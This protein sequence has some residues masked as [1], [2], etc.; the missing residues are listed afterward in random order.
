MVLAG[1]VAGAAYSPAL[2]NGFTLDDQAIVEEN[3]AAHDVGAA[4]RAA[5]SSYWP[6]PH[7]AGQWRPL[8][9]LSFATD[10][11]LSGG[12]AAWLHAGNVL[13][14]ATATALLV[15][16][17]IPYAGLAGATVGALVFAVHPVHVEAVAN[18]VGRAELMAAVLLL[19]AVLFA[20]AG[21]A[22]VAAG[23][24]A[25]GCEVGVLACLALALLSKEHAAVGILLLVLDRWALTTHP[26]LRL[27]ARLVAAALALTAIWFVAR[28]Q[29][30]VGRSF[31]AVAPTFFDQDAT[32]RLATMLPVVFHVVRLL[33]WPFQLSPDYHP[34]VVDRLDAVT[35][36]GLAGAAFLLLLLALGL[37]VRRRHPAVSAALGFVAIAWL[38]TA[39]LLFPTGIVLSERTLY[40]ASVGIALLAGLGAVALERRYGRRVATAL[41]VA[42][43]TAFGARTLTRIPIWESTRTLVLEGVL[44]RPESYKVRQAAARVLMRT[45]DVPAALRE[46]GVAAELYDWDPFLLAE[47]GSAALAGGQPLVALRFLEL[48]LARD[49]TYT[50]TRQLLE[51]ARREACDERPRLQNARCR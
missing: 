49:S 16:V 12:R 9:I 10:W 39:N 7:D 15:P 1:L 2:R 42:T 5:G 13:W 33:V 48:A 28:A 18:L 21:A 32:G 24:S 19:L 22:R 50:L 17:L 45:G 11:Q 27:R 23:A 8:V 31:A 34:R 40:L 38:P 3:P 30:D 46:Y 44:T 20:R 26:A 47:A 25:A 43:V 51:R 29:I 4:L 14:H 36:L 35:P 37:A 41:L 6:P